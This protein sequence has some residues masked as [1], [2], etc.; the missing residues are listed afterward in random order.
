MANRLLPTALAVIL[1][2]A[3]PASVAKGTTKSASAWQEGYVTA[4]D[5]VRLYYRLV[6]E[7]GPVVLIP[8]GLFL[9][10]DFAHLASNRRLVFYDMRNRGRSDAVAD[11][12]RISIQQDVLDLDAVRRW[13]GADEVMLIGWSYLG[14]MVMRYV[15]EYPGRVLRIVQIGPLSRRFRSPFPDSL[16]AHDP[17]PV[18]DSASL[19]ELARLRETGLPAENP[20]AYCEA[21]YR[22]NRVRLV[23]DPRRADQVPDQCGLRNEWPP[24]LERHFRLLFGSIIRQDP[25]PWDRFARL[26]LPVLTIHGTQDRNAPYG[27]GR[28][29]VLHLPGA[30]LLTVHGAAHMV[31]LDAPEIVFT[32]IDQFL[33]GDWPRAARRVRL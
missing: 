6:G 23:G 20:G 33:G 9:E 24:A 17:T 10:R 12:T 32:A 5:G 16:V 14:M 31:W 21:D 18:P 30:R 2:L 27:G 26:D 15:A 1:V 11:S 7:A 13:V 29:W 19:A 8:G 25:P 28:E 3:P 4:D 22:I